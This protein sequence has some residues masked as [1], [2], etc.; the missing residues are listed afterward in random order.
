M[1]IWVP[2]YVFTSQ[3]DLDHDLSASG[4]NAI[5]VFIPWDSRLLYISLFF[6]K[7]FHY[8]LSFWVHT[9]KEHLAD[10]KIERF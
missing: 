7:N 5:L 6:H 3:S 9:W 10:F 1:W 8:F 2:Y 4:L